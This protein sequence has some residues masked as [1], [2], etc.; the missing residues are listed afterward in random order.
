MKVLLC[1]DEDT[2]GLLCPVLGSSVQERYQTSRDSPV[3]GHKDDEWSAVSPLL[4]EAE[5]PEAVQPGEEK[6]EGRSYQCL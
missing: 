3:E 2:S 5:K 1:P 6:T 4:G